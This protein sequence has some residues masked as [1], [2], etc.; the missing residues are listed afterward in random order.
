M[1][2]K[3]LEAPIG[4]FD[5]GV[6]GL[7]VMRAITD[8]LP[9]ENVVYFGDTA[10]APWGEKSA[11]SI[12]TFSL[13]IADL[14]LA[15]GCKAIVIACHTASA[16]AHD[17]LQE[18][19]GHRALIVD[20]IQPTVQYLNEHFEGTKIGLIGTKQTIRSNIYQK[21][22]DACQRK[23][24]LRS[25]ATPLLAPL[26]EEGYHDHQLTREI[27]EE[28]LDNPL[29]RGIDGLIL[30]CTHYP[31]IRE[32]VELFYQKKACHT[33]VI[34][35]ACLAAEALKALLMASNSLNHQLTKPHRRAFVSDYTPFFEQATKIFY[36]HDVTLEPYPL[37]N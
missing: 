24:E 17:L 6:G 15:K 10:H 37:W 30:G 36:G 26:I 32:R 33:P 34:D 2:Q 19:L 11:E 5:S 4:I 27:I 12:Q 8:L 3:Q 20:V 14:L 16:L 21:Y 13:R 23:I 18:H 28:Y 1:I 9:Q 25:L 22:T 7:T 31:I 29:L 35:A